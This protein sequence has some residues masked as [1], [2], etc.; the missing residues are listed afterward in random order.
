MHSMVRRLITMFMM[1]AF[2][3]V[4]VVSFSYFR[5]DPQIGAM[6]SLVLFF[7]GIILLVRYK[8]KRK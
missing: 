3:A 8:P 1:A 6:L 2:F 5:I 7:A 4:L